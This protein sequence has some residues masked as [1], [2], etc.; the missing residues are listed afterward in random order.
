MRFS[1]TPE[2]IKD[3]IDKNRELE[4]FAN[5]LMTKD[6]YKRL[7]DMVNGKTWGSSVPY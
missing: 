2:Q 4:D 7:A 3:A 1:D 5:E 6:E